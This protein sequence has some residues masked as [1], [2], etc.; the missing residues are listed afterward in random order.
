M[1]GNGWYKRTETVS[2][3]SDG[4]IRDIMGIVPEDKPM[5]IVI[6]QFREYLKSIH[7]KDDELGLGVIDPM[8]RFNIDADDS[9]I[10]YISCMTDNMKFSWSIKIWEERLR[11]QSFF[12]IHVPFFF[13]DR[14]IIR[15]Y[16]KNAGYCEAI[17]DK[18]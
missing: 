16:V 3:I 1:K 12:F 5:D 4:Y 14:Y 8:I 15:V 2:E 7:G 13:F 6:G 10:G 11:K 18:N 17:L 9:G